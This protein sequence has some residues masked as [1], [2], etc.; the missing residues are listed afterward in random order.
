ML[1][2]P[3]AV[4]AQMRLG[5]P[6]QALFIVSLN[7]AIIAVIGEL[8]PATWV[9]GPLAFWILALGFG[10]IASSCVLRGT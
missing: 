10:I 1:V 5:A 7:L 9:A 4:E 3:L 8:L 2:L 6:S